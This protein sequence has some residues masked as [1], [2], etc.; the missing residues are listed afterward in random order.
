MVDCLALPT[1][2]LGSTVGLHD[3]TVSFQ[4][5]RPLSVLLFCPVMLLVRPQEGCEVMRSACLSVCLSVLS[6]ISTRRPTLAGR[7]ARRHVLP[8]GV[9]PFA[10]RYQGNGATPRQYIDITRKAIDWATTLP[11]SFLYN[12]T[13]QQT[14]RHLL[15]K[16]SE[17]RQI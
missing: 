9:G 1:A 13:L 17:R 3:L 5:S 7:T 12:E 11:L 4:K 14:F 2:K 15:S 16:L 8:M 10:F 6:H